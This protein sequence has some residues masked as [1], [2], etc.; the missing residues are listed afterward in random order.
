MRTIPAIPRAV[1]LSLLLAAVRA[2]AVCTTNPILLP[3]H[4]RVG[5]DTAHCQ[6]DDIQSAIDAVGECPTIVD[7]TREHLY[8][9]QHL[10]IADKPNLTLQGWGDGVTCAD[11]RGTLSFPPYAPPDSTAPL[12]TIN[13]S[14]DGGGTVLY[15]TGNTNLAVRNLTISGGLTCADCSGGGISFGGQGS[16]ALTRSTI[17]FNEAAFGAGINVNGSSG[18][19]TLTLDSDTLVLSNT[20]DISGGG[21]RVE[22]NTRLY[23]LKPNTMIAFNKA[24]NGYGGGIEVLGP[25]RADIGSPGYGGLGVIYD[26]QAQYGGGID[27]LTFDDG[28][29][30]I[31]RLFTTDRAKPVR[32]QGNAA[33]HTGGAVYLKPHRTFVSGGTSVAFCAYDFV[34]DDNI[35]MEGAA[36]YSDADYS[37]DGF[38]TGGTVAL[39]TDPN[40]GRLCTQTEPPTALGAVAC[41]AGTACNRIEGNH[42]EDGTGQPTDGSTLL[43]QDASEVEADRVEFRAN[44][45]AH[46]LRQ[47]GHAGDQ[48][49]YITNGLF[50]D[51]A[52]TQELVAQTDA[53]DSSLLGLDSCTIAGNTIGAPYVFLATGN[54]KLFNSIVDQPGRATADPAITDPA[55]AAH[56]L[57]N[58]RSTL[59][60]TAYIDEGE[61]TFVN[62]ANGD[63]HLVSTSLGIDATP[64]DVYYYP[65]PHADLDR[66]PRVVDLP[67]VPNNF[68]PMDLG[69][70]EIQPACSSADTV[71]CN[72]FE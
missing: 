4:Y 47:V 46:V 60:D 69:A 51:N 22:G 21:I 44:A 23:A 40:P 25:A 68:G 7:I 65:A 70:Y 12:L 1:A 53:D 9:H 41:A 34:V 71:F 18:A 13:G 33:S 16:L 52:L 31:V 55:R 28:A 19:A 45:G 58:D 72:G 39:N 64:I 29:E 62:A 50:A 20:A 48:Y 59:P 26:N 15:V 54:F 24:P 6:Y 11:I 42:A 5:A 43:V 63:Y 8:T 2:H 27:I 56:V 57:S 61:P 17:S 10:G 14:S 35:A 37:T 32:M 3:L 66:R 49:A 67:N 38:A 30:A 36:I